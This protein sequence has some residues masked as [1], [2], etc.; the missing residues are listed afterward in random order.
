MTL[1]RYYNG[2][3]SHISGVYFIRLFICALNILYE[4][5]NYSRPTHSYHLWVDCASPVLPGHS[6]VWRDLVEFVEL[7]GSQ[8]QAQPPVSFRVA[9]ICLVPFALAS[10]VLRLGGCVTPIRSSLSVSCSLAI[11][12]GPWEI[13][14]ASLEQQK[15][16]IQGEMLPPRRI[17]GGDPPATHVLCTEDSRAPSLAPVRATPEHQRKLGRP[18]GESHS[19]SPVGSPFLP[20]GRIPHSHQETSSSHPLNGSVTRASEKSGHFW[21]SRKPIN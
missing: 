3:I 18:R 14:T 17:E 4:G 15:S 11:S 13:L 7:H 21:S 10:S 8:A 16:K 5:D 1:N 2:T 20:Y 19:A 12:L 6:P 9:L